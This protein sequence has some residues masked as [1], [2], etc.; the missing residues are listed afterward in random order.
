[1][2]NMLKLVVVGTALLTGVT[3]V[4]AAR[5]LTNTEMAQLKVATDE[6]ENK[7][8]TAE[9]LESHKVPAGITKDNIQEFDNEK[10]VLEQMDKYLE[11]APSSDENKK[12]ATWLRKTS[13]YLDWVKTE[14]NK[15]AASSLGQ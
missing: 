4:V 9:A 1:M 3:G 5:D 7:G 8:F 10:A 2:K 12:Q 14:V 15:P 11:E 6:L 13:G